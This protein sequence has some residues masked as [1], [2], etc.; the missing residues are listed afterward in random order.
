MCNYICTL[1]E[2][3]KFFKAKISIGPNCISFK[4]FWTSLGQKQFILSTYKASNCL[5]FRC[6]FARKKIGF[7]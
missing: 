1:K 4:M 7:G 2:N 6:Q 3:K 5:V